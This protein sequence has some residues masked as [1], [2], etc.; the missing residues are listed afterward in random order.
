MIPTQA[1][2]I[3]AAANS[4]PPT[5]A[6]VT[7][8]AIHGSAQA[9]RASVSERARRG[10]RG[11]AGPGRRRAAAAGRSGGCGAGRSKSSSESNGTLTL[12]R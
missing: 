2:P 6:I 8:I 10:L 9:I 1:K 11:A 7:T 4:S 3:I 5:I 12:H